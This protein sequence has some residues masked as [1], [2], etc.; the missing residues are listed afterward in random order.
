MLLHAT[1]C[2]QDIAY[3]TDLG[4]LN[5]S[6]EKCEEII[7]KLYIPALQGPVKPRT[8]REKARKVYLNT[9]KKKNKTRAEIKTAIGRQIRYVS[10][11]LKL[12]DTLLAAFEENPLKEQNRM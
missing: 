6:R 3:P 9:A 8:H 1:V 7:E 12:I 11:N 2:P 10:R 4:H 5:A